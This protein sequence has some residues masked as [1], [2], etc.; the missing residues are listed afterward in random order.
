MNF[1]EKFCKQLAFPSLLLTKAVELLETF[2]KY[3]SVANYDPL[4]HLNL[5]VAPVALP[6]FSEMASLGLE[7]NRLFSDYQGRWPGRRVSLKYQ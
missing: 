6:P 2:K 4:D 1:K 3:C 5:F 7:L